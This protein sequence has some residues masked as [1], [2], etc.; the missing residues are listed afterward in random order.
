MERIKNIDIDGLILYDLQDESSRSAQQ[1]P[2]PFIETLPPDYY[3]ETYLHQLQ[4][5]KII[6]KSVGK[7]NESSFQKWTSQAASPFMVMVGAP[8]SNTAPE[9]SLNR[10]YELLNMAEKPMLLGGVTIPERHAAK[11]NEHLRIIE[12]A[13]KGCGYFITQ[14]VYDVNNAKN[15]LSDYYYEAQTNGTPLL[16]I[17]FSLTPCGSLKTLEFTKWLGIHIPK[18]LEND[19]L[20][21]EDILSGSIE[22]CKSTALELIDFCQKKQIPIGFN[23]IGRAHV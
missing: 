7:F 12:K 2:F 19:L 18:W 10:A 22:V 3:A 4:I 9:L 15:F 5:P 21:A 8:S 13:E 14:C 11:G 16:P 20:H 17:I 6:Y 1:R 23:K